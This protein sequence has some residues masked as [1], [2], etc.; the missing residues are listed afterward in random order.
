MTFEFFSRCAWLAV[1]ALGSSACAPE[2]IT[3][4]E[5]TGVAPAR[6]HRGNIVGTSLELRYTHC[7]G[8][9][10][11]LI[12]GDKE[13]SSCVKKLHAGSLAQ[14]K[15]VEVWDELGGHDWEVRSVGTCRRDPDPEDRGGYAL[16]RDCKDLPLG[17]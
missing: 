6:D 2:R 16:T 15:L 8:D 4:V 10:R 17:R 13:F 5:V 3:D 14:V 1:F 12:R 11:E 7:R 9:Q